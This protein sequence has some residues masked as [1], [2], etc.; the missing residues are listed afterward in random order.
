MAT[1]HIENALGIRLVRIEP[2]SFVMGEHGGI[3][4]EAPAHVV[5]ITSPCY[6]AT[7]PVTNAQWEQFRPEARKTR[8]EWGLSEEDD[9][10]VIFVSWHDAVAF[11]EWLSQKEGMPYRLPT[12]AEWEHACRA[13]TTTAYWTGDTLPE[14][15]RRD[16]PD[17]RKKTRVVVE[18]G[19]DPLVVARSPPNPWGLHDMHG[20]VEEWCLDWHGPYEHPP[21]APP[22]VDQAFAEAAEDPAPSRVDGG[23][24]GEDPPAVDPVGRVPGHHG[25]WKVTRGGSYEALVKHLRSASRAAQHPASRSRFIGFRVVQAPPVAGTPLPLGPPPL[26]QVNVNRQLFAWNDDGRASEPIWHPPVPYINPPPTA[27]NAGEFRLYPHN[28]SPAITWCDNGDLLAAWFSCVGEHDRDSFVILAARRVPGAASWGPPSLFYKCPGRNM[29]GTSLFNDGKG[30]LLHFNGSDEASGW[31]SLIMTLR[32]STDNGATW[33]E[34]RSIG[35]P[36]GFRNQVI[37]CTRRLSNGRLVQLCDATP[38]PGGGTAAWVSDDDGI[39]WRDAGAGQ[40][41]PSFK[42]GKTGA[43]IAGRHASVEELGD[44]RLLAF[45]RD[46]AIDGQAPRSISKDGGE[47]WEYGASG[48][49]AVSWGQRF[50]LMRLHHS[51]GKPLVFFSFTNTRRAEGEKEPGDGIDI[52]DAAGKTRR[53]FGLFSALSFDDGETWTNHKLLSDGSGAVL[54]R[55]DYRTFFTMEATHG[56]FSGYMAACQSPDGMIHMVSSSLHYSFNLAWLRTPTV[57]G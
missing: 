4:D 34:P 53:I 44:G 38:P 25:A 28:H 39:T 19:I 55:A 21:T 6:M 22:P 1:R 14:E 23:L 51:P 47:T 36:H 43:W 35:G 24:Q 32:E 45:G 11:C 8:G 30:R 41:S 54:P 48:F 5:R 9:S 20:L 27:P 57:P 13:G 10:A 56:E 29:T 12:E 26:H 42:A 33:S 50:V 46:D 49:P 16:N 18:D 37:A 31:S 40:P 52:V 17:E 3:L 2:G 7:T 15:H